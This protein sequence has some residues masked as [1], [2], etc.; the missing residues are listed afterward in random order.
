M[1]HE[2]RAGWD[3]YSTGC[4]LGQQ[5]YFWKYTGNPRQLSIWWRTPVFDRR[6]TV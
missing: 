6:E 5:Q 2:M 3:G 4:R 1:L